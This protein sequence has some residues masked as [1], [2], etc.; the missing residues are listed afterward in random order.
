VSLLNPLEDPKPAWSFKTEFLKDDSAEFVL[1]GVRGDKENLLETAGLAALKV[2]EM[3]A[4]GPA[5]HL[6]RSLQDY[7]IYCPNTCGAQSRMR[8]CVCPLGFLVEG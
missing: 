8:R 6:L 5:T 7:A 4:D 2:V 3:P 1:R